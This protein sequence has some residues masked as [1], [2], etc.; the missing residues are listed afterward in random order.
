MFGG[1][2]LQGDLGF[3]FDPD[4]KV[5]IDGRGTVGL[6]PDFFGE[7]GDL[8]GQDLRNQSYERVSLS[9]VRFKESLLDDTSFKNSVLLSP[10]FTR[11]SLRGSI[12][13]QGKI[14]DGNF[15]LTDLRT[16]NFINVDLTGSFVGSN[17]RGVKIQGDALV[18]S[19]FT[20]AMMDQ[21]ILSHANFVNCDFTAASAQNSDFSH[22]ELRRLFFVRT[23]LRHAIFSGSTLIGIEFRGADL[24]GA[25][26]RGSQLV[27]VVFEGSYFDDLTELPFSREEALR[28]GMIKK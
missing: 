21:S 24:S 26:F 8:T 20:K 1:V 4:N 3:R 11:A 16:A 12:F 19:D 18:K 5:C 23:K 14:R 28:R 15:S 9:G 13:E 7:C 25:S 22:S 6:N 2:F 10:D 17:L 27:D